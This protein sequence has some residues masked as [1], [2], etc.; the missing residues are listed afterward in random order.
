M[1]PK[2]HSPQERHINPKSMLNLLRNCCKY[3]IS[4]DVST[5]LSV[6]VRKVR[7]TTFFFLMYVF[8]S[9]YIFYPCLNVT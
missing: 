6:H 7:S 4:N 8:F 3:F 2:S 5:P 9:S 1:H